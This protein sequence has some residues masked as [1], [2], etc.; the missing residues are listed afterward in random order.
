MLAAD[1]DITISTAVALHKDLLDRNRHLAFGFESVMYLT[2]S[3]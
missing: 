2:Q 3:V 1:L